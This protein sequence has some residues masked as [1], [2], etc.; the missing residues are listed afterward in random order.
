MGSGSGTSY[1]PEYRRPVGAGDGDTYV[2]DTPA[3]KA[4]IAELEAALLGA[5]IALT[6]D[7]NIDAAVAIILAAKR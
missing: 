4:R 6:R 7:Q 3:L 1:R 5:E 2:V